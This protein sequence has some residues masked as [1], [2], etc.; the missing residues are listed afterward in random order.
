MLC[1]GSLLCNLQCESS[2]LCFVYFLRPATAT[3][4]I[5]L[6]SSRSMLSPVLLLEKLS[7]KAQ[8]LMLTQQKN[9]AKTSEIFAKLYWSFIYEMGRR[10]TSLKYSEVA[11]TKEFPTSYRIL[12]QNLPK[13]SAY[14]CISSVRQLLNSSI[15]FIE[16]LC[17]FYGGKFIEF[18]NKLYWTIM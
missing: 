6:K 18:F 12:R 8:G 7:A 15:N 3:H 1:E 10:K 14:F 11:V 4:N 9:F 2:P 17:N 13:P 5:Y 16:L